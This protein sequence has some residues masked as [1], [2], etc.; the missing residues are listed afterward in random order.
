MITAQNSEEKFRENE[1]KATNLLNTLPPIQQIDKSSS[2][3]EAHVNT[4]GQNDGQACLNN[5][6]SIIPLLKLYY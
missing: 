2:T 1:E 5:S 6:T 3:K 4:L